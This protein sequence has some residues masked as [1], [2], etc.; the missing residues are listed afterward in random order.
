M[1]STLIRL[2]G[3]NVKIT[4]KTQ[5]LGFKISSLYFIH[6]A[7]AIKY[8]RCMSNRHTVQDT[9]ERDTRQFYKNVHFNVAK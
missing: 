6:F 2:H 5:Y 7:T 8:I 9:S 1:Q 3:N 4:I